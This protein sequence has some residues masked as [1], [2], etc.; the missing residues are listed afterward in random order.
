MLNY[1]IKKIKPLLFLFLFSFF[2]FF[3]ALTINGCGGGDSPQTAGDGAARTIEIEGKLPGAALLSAPAPNAA[4]NAAG[5]YGAH[6]SISVIDSDNPG[7][8]IGSVIVK[9]GAYLASIASAA[10]STAPKII[11]KNNANN[12]ILYQCVFGKIPA[13]SQIPDKIKKIKLSG[14]DINESSTARAL[15]AGDKKIGLASIIS[16]DTLEINAADEIIYLNY[17][18]KK[19]PADDQIEKNCGGALMI[20]ELAKAVKTVTFAAESNISESFKISFIPLNI[21]GVTELLKSFAAVAGYPGAQTVI[22][23]NNLPASINVSGTIINSSSV[24]DNSINELINKI[25]PVEKVIKPEFS[26]AGGI[27]KY[28]VEVSIAC[29]TPGAVI[30]YALSDPAKAGPPVYNI[31]DGRPVVIKNTSAIAAFAVKEGLADSDIAKALYTIDTAP[32]VITA[33]YV[34]SDNALNIYSARAGNTIKMNFAVSEV[35]GGMPLVKICGHSVG[36]VKIDDENYTAFYVMGTNETEGKIKIIIEMIDAAGNSGVKS[37]TSDIIYYKTNSISTLSG[38][39][40]HA[41]TYD[42]AEDAGKGAAQANV[43]LRRK[44]EPNS[45]P[46]FS[47]KTS[48]KGYFSLA[49]LLAGEYLLS[50]SLKNDS[51]GALLKNESFVSIAAETPGYTL[52]GPLELYNASTLEITVND[53]SGSPLQSARIFLNDYKNRYTDKKGGAVFTEVPEGVYKLEIIKEGFINKIEYIAAG[54]TPMKL[55]YTLQRA[56]AGIKSLSVS[57]LDTAG[58]GFEIYENG[59]LAIS[60]TSD[61]PNGGNLKFSW[62]AS[63]GYIESTSE[64]AM[65]GGLNKCEMIWRAPALENESG[66]ISKVYYITAAVDD[67]KSPATSRGAAVKVFK[68]SA[69]KIIITSKPET[70]AALNADYNY[71][72]IAVDE[73]SNIIPPSALSYSVESTPA[74]GA[75]E[76][77]TLNS[78]SGE[79]TWK[80]SVRGKFDFILKV[81]AKSGGNYAVEQ[82]SVTVDEHIG[83]LKAGETFSKTVLKPGSGLSI[84]LKNLKTSE[85]VIAMP[86]NTD[87]SKISS[88]NMAF[89]KTGEANSAPDSSA[90]A[91]PLKAAAN[92]EYYDND[93]MSRHLKFE[94]KK[95]KRDFEFLKKYGKY[96]DYNRNSVQ[97]P[98]K[99]AAEPLIGTQKDF[100]VENSDPSLNYGWTKVRATL[101]ACGKHCYVYVENDTPA[102][103]LPLDGETVNLIVREFDKSYEKITSAFG[104]EP[105]PGL[106]NDSRIYI[107]A[108]HLVNVQEAAG[109]FSFINTLPQRHFDEES[110]PDSFGNNGTG[111]KI[112]SNEKEMFYIFMPDASNN[113]AKYNNF[114]GSLLSHE[115]QHMVNFYQHSL[116]IDDFFNKCTRT[117]DDFLRYLWL[118]EGLSMMAMD[119][120]GYNDS[121]VYGRTFLKKVEN[122]A[123][124]DFTIYENYGLSYLFVKYL[125]EQGALI[126]NLVKSDKINLKNAEAE[127][128]SKN[129]AADFDDFFANFISTLYLSN[130][131]ITSDPKFNY[132]GISLR[133]EII[134]DNMRMTLNG[135]S[136]AAE[137]ISPSSYNGVCLKQYGFNVIKCAAAIQGDHKLALSGG[138]IDKTGV[139]I[140]RIKK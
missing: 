35:L 124:L 123:L 10:V 114:L 11:I 19:T 115:F 48:E 104:S 37:G 22:A 18:G 60:I 99:Q 8:S 98:L 28:T 109:Y 69:G 50:A 77:F 140:L 44:T 88:Y 75:G 103:Y 126:S 111:R 139:V 68:K 36:A 46:L 72:I 91:R 106:D 43:E 1:L 52:P 113:G 136:I 100:M 65:A 84:T 64:T 73:S 41:G 45:P 90:A 132:S 119:F 47:T 4:G 53:E 92:D 138:N 26:L 105:N 121:I 134:N 85:Y 31:F 3:L 40:I 2:F 61:N 21:S 120:C 17:E 130:T 42:K 95:H 94:L 39:I 87:E 122:T 128:I 102:S 16:I 125:V 107:L 67:Q 135:P 20:A 49:D 86:Y 101:K 9:D 127:I 93:L 30:K 63:G 7:A 76:S 96:I 33:L 89:Y 51:S 5:I 15:V 97:A 34:V 24:N 23:Q 27:Y 133:S 14:I 110:D 56:A 112:Y 71:K 25:K 83:E 62:Q 32:P 55:T 6:N 57:L 81:C 13:S 79:I 80:P 54:K 29:E 117:M 82:F 12:R 129:I 74:P 38:Y 66:P 78:D 131:G 70:S 59:T 58:A 116:A 137:L 108:T 118:N